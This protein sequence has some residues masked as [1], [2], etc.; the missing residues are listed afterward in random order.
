VLTLHQ[1]RLNLGRARAVENALWSLGVHDIAVLLHLV[2]DEPVN[3]SVVGHSAVVPRIEDDVYLH[4]DFPTGVRAHLH[5]S[6][7]WPQRQRRLTIVG[8]MGMLVFD[9]TSQTVTLH[10]KGINPDLT[11]RDE[12]ERVVFTGAE[13]PLQLEMQHF[14]ECVQNRQ[15]PLSDGLNGLHV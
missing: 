11:N 14:L 9:E 3:L 15:A 7:L 6:W 4:L 5:V 2:G 10:D 13:E 12:G 1:E 8:S